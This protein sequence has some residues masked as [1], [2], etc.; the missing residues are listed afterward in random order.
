MG[1]FEAVRQ[2]VE[3][4]F[5]DTYSSVELRLMEL[6]YSLKDTILSNRLRH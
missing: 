3:K 2:I 5:F 4:R 6:R 1:S